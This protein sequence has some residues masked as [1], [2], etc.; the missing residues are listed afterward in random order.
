M[1]LASFLFIRTRQVRPGSFLSGLYDFL[2]LFSLSKKFITLAKELML[3]TL[4][5]LLTLMEYGSNSGLSPLFV[6]DDRLHL[7][8]KFRIE[9][10]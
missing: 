4:V 9:Q 5:G 7:L 1:K 2:A 3:P 10:G 8:L 6:I